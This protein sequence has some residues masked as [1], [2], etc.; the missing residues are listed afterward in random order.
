MIIYSLVLIIMM[1]YR[2][3]GLLGTKE[4]TSFFKGRKS[5]KGGNV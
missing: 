1:I 5:A 3:Q 4:L 2:P